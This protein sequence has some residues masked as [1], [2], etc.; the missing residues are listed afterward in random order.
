[1]LWNL[2]PEVFNEW[3]ANNDLPIVYQHFLGLLPAFHEWTAESGIDRAVF[4]RTVP[5][6]ELFS[7]NA[8]ITMVRRQEDRSPLYSYRPMVIPDKELFSK[9]YEA[10]GRPGP[11]MK[12]VTPYFLWCKNR[13][14]SSEVVPLD[15]N[16]VST[17]V[18]NSWSAFDMPTASR[19]SLFRAFEVLKLGGV[20]IPTGIELAGRNLDFAD[21][22]HLT[23]EGKWH[24]SS[25]LNICF[26]S[27]RNITIRGR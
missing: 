26:A 25:A 24:G 22:D 19:A 14:G 27:C 1:M 9:R 16:K 11:M 21:L 12:D 4:C 5:V 8:Q 6:G 17:F 13:F 2:S 15:G 23:I 7:G 3:R 10:N 20:K 18:F